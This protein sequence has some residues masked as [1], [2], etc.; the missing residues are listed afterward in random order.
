MYSTYLTLLVPAIIAFMITAVSTLFLI[1]YMKE[2]GITSLDH[3]KR[4][5]PQIPGGGGVALAFGFTVG[6][7]V[8]VFGGSFGLYIPVA[9]YTYLFA[10][11]LA[12]L[13]ISFGG[14]LDDL[15][16]QP[17]KTRS[18]GMMDYRKGLKQWQ[19][20]LLTLIGAIPLMA[21]NAGVSIVHIPF[22]G[23]VNFGILY[24]LLIIPL[25]ILYASNAFNL[26]GG[27]DGL[28]SGS[29]V[30][31]SLALLLYSLAFGTYSG[32]LVS[33]VLFAS[34]V[35][36]LI[37][38][39]YPARIHPG[40]SFTYAIGAGFIAAIVIGNMEAFGFIVFL[41]WLIEFL[42][43]LRRRFDVTDLGKMRSD[44]TMEPPYGKKIYSWTHLIMNLKKCKEWE[45]SLY[46]WLI[47]IGFVLLAFGIVLASGM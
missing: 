32:A 19:K 37:F 15:N 43:H 38:N 46:M 45:V 5:K 23:T 18:T 44:G 30:I 42:L 36:F 8:Y 16:V 33:V 27:F 21:V 1:S 47:E 31:V 11:I 7:L 22:L 26:L 34:S 4:S 29:A 6:M 41:P 13:L 12:V 25:A 35:A 14:F 2:S 28:S 3:Y 39:I 40:D 10:T 17:S 20:P 24:P 9:D